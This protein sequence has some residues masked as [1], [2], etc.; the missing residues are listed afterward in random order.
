MKAI[1]AWA[2]ERDAEIVTLE[3]LLDSRVM[4]STFV[5]L[6]RLKSF[7]LSK[8]LLILLWM[9][10]SFEGQASLR[11]PSLRSLPSISSMPVAYVDYD[12]KNNVYTPAD[13]W[14]SSID[15]VRAIYCTT[16][17][18]PEN[19]KQS[20]RDQAAQVKD[21]GLSKD[22]DVHSAIFILD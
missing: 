1:A 19:I 3:Q 22:N 11:I 6:L 18:D 9:L 10:S 2:I 15:S 17:I 8:L 13:W 14:F 5:I 21:R 7:N 16:L 4:D 12:F 20:P